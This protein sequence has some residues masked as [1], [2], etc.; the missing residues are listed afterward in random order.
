MREI[1]PMRPVRDS[2]SIPTSTD[3][4]WIVAVWL[5][6]IVAASIT[7]AV[8][9][10]SRSTAI[11]GALVTAAGAGFAVAGTARTLRENPNQ[12]V[13]WWGRPTNCPRRWD[14]LAGTG[15][16]LAAYGAILTGRSVDRL[17]GVVFPLSVMAV[18]TLI[19][20]AAQAWH[21]R[22]VAAG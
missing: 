5:F 18:L 17:S 3:P 14:L 13:P 9:P 22:R 19:L 4:S 15:I 21:N 11:V 7:M 20:C 8:V 16:P 1:P 6:A 2:D 12:R 10:T